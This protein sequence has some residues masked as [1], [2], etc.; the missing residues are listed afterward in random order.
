MRAPLETVDLGWMTAGARGR[1]RRRVHGARRVAAVRDPAVRGGRVCRP[2]VTA[3]TFLAAD[4]VPRM[5]RRHPLVD[6]RDRRCRP[7]Q[8]Q[9]T[10]RALIR[11]GRARQLRSGINCRGQSEPA[12]THRD[13]LVREP[14]GDVATILEAH[15]SSLPVSCEPSAPDR[16]LDG[17]SDSWSNQTAPCPEG[18]GRARQ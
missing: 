8:F 4:T 5:S 1:E 10:N 17:R 11:R 2:A 18:C 3:V 15:G 13:W 14:L 6:M 12:Q 7:D 16:W 9:M